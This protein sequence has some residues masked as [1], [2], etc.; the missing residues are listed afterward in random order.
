MAKKA[1]RKVV[2]K[3]SIKDYDYEK[4]TPSQEKEWIA[5]Q[6][7]EEARK[8]GRNKYIFIKGTISWSL[9]TIGILILL[10][11]LTNKFSSN[12]ELLW[13][14]LKMYILF[15][16]LGTLFGIGTWH[17]SEKKYISFYKKEKEKN[18]SK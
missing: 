5:V 3:E 12:Q 13:Y 7:W 4:R 16:G 11:L 2:K 8:M 10:T 9:M 17:L 14:F 18:T 15:I 1:K 6:K